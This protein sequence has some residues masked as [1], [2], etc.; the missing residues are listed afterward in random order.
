M[1]LKIF[2]TIPTM[3]L[4]SNPKQ[5]SHQAEDQAPLRQLWKPLPNKSVSYPSAAQ[6]IN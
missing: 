2:N 3:L 6:H 4:F 5:S 1:E